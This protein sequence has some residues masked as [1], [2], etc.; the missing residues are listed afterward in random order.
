MASNKG[1]KAADRSAEP[2]EE[3]E[4]DPVADLPGLPRVE[5]IGWV[6]RPKPQVVEKKTIPPKAVVAFT[7]R[8]FTPRPK[9]AMV[10]MSDLGMGGTA[11]GET[12]PAR[13]KRRD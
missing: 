13:N 12:K 4:H 6:V 5:E 11:R 3:E 9:T 2:A 1:K 7:L 10:T 8:P